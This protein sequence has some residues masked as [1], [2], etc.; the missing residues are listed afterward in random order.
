[1]SDRVNA[2][3]YDPNKDYASMST[4]QKDEYNRRVA[5]NRNKK[6]VLFGANPHVP[7]I[8]PGDSI[9]TAYIKKETGPDASQG[10]NS[11]IG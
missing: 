9:H 3:T 5:K 2:I 1:M 8:A 10:A 6:P 4:D 11:I 7:K